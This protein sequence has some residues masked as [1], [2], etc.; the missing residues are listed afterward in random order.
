M[1]EIYCM[2]LWTGWNLRLYAIPSVL[3]LWGH[4][5]RGS[6]ALGSSSL[7]VRDGEHF[8]LNLQSSPV[9]PTRPLFLRW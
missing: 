4:D 7:L 6:Q 5:S 2:K 1:Y 9:E 3:L 8:S